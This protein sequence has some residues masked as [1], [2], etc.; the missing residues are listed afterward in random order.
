[1]LLISL[2]FTALV[3]RDEM[4]VVASAGYFALYQQQAATGL[5]AGPLV[6][7]ICFIPGVCSCW[8]VQVATAYSA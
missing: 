4:A 1:M 2:P 5:N 3:I 8:P 7:S 6:L